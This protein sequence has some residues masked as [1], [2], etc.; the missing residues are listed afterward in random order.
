MEK[1]EPEQNKTKFVDALVAFWLC[2]CFSKPQRIVLSYRKDR[3]RRI[4]FVRRWLAAGSQ[5]EQSLE[6]SHGLFATIAETST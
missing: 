2:T 4:F 5:T 6:R 1:D 3:L